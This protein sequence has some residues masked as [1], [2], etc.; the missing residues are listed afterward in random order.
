MMKYEIFKEVVS[1]TF[2][3]YLPEKYRDMELRVESVSKV[4]RILDGITL[5]R[6][7]A[8]KNISPTVYIND[9][10][11]HYLK[12][13]DLKEVIR[14]GANL[15]VKGFSECPEIPQIDLALAKDNIVFQLVNTEQNK[16]MLA[17]ISH[18]E[19]Q[20]LAVIYRWVV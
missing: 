10:Y 6:A 19:F 13:N 11:D 8:E 16:D 15:M 1:D 4:N 18:R 7:G 2:K 3:D 5:I 20:D 17:G 14:T 12:C 9:M